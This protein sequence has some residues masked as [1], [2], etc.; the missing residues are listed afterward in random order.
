[1]GGKKDEHADRS[2]CDTTE[3]W[4]QHSRQWWEVTHWEPT[5]G[6]WDGKES[7]NIIHMSGSCRRIKSECNVRSSV[8]TTDTCMGSCRSP[9]PR[10]QALNLSS[11]T[12]YTCRDDGC[13]MTTVTKPALLVGR[14]KRS[15]A[16]CSGALASWV[17]M[18][19]VVLCY[20][21]RESDLP[22]SGTSSAW[23]AIYN[24]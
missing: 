7:W 8:V 12:F 21:R 9:L 11:D 20:C 5:G 18:I 23:A 6:C 1:M 14:P 17:T 15:E 22:G 13:C 16:F 2:K 24:D 10:Q 19:K 4:T 3:A